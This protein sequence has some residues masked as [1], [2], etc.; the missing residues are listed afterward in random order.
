MVVLR[1]RGERGGSMKKLL[2]KRRMFLA[3]LLGSWFLMEPVVSRAQTQPAAFDPSGKNFQKETTQDYNRRLEQLRQSLAE[4]TTASQVG[5]YRIGAHDVIEVNVF[6]APELNRSLRV[7]AGGEISVPLVGGVEA[8]GLT[9]R[10][11][12][13]VLEERLREFIK[14]PHVGVSVS[15]IESHPVSVVGA[16]KK[17]G[18]FQ[19]RGPKTVLEMLS[20]AEGLADDAGDDVLVMR[21]AGLRQGATPTNEANEPN[22]AHSPASSEV[23]PLPNAGAGNDDPN[24]KDT[25]KVNLKKVLDSGDPRYNVAVYPGD[26]VKVP[27][28]GIVYVVGGVNK[29]GGFV[30]KSNE[31]MSVLKAVALAEGLTRTSSK[32]RARIIRTDEGTGERSEVAINLGK[33]L[34]GKA[35]DPALKSAD[36]VFVPDSATKGALYR[37]SEAALQTAVGVAIWR[38]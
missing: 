36:I 1:V 8:A 7:S 38:W 13:G 35:P 9:A 26:I 16:V 25:V 21:G 6:E 22:A 12:E 28:A 11:V 24:E 33:I 19:L 23:A 37:G 14:D 5:D 2:E 10:E 27:R 4:R 17:P 18:V 30:M 20:L 34:G 15:A 3:V 32:G 31:K 29:P